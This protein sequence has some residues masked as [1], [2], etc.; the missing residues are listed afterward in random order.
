MKEN[1]IVEGIEITMETLVGSFGKYPRKFGN[2]FSMRTNNDKHYRIVNFNVEN[3][4]ELIRLEVKLPVK[5]L[6]LRDGTAVICDERIPDEWYNTEY[7]S[8]CCPHDLLPHPQQARY[9]RQIMRGDRRE[10]TTEIDGVKMTIV[11]SRLGGSEKTVG[12]KGKT[13][14]DSPLIYAPWLPTMKVLEDDE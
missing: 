4:R 7:C 6:P 2:C 14:E 12:Y 8:V 1:D 5:L 10:I 3:L 11:K 9:I 13:V